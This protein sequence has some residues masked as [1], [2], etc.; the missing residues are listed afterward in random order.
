MSPAVIE[1][2]VSGNILTGLFAQ[3]NNGVA[4]NNKLLGIKGGECP[5]FTQDIQKLFNTLFASVTLALLQIGRTIDNP[6]YVFMAEINKSSQISFRKKLIDGLGDFKWCF[7]RGA[8]CSCKNYRIVPAL[9]YKC[10]TID[11]CLF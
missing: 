11:E 7:Y 4:L 9:K 3:C 8:I 5:G 10:T 6:V 1:R 2:L